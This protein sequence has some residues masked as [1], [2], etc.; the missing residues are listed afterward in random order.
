MQTFSLDPPDN[1][2]HNFTG[3]PNH[4]GTGGA[5][6]L[7]DSGDANYTYTTSLTTGS[8]TTLSTYDALTPPSGD[9]RRS[10]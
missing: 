5:D 6:A 7:F 9:Q 2:R 3:Y 1:D 8:T 4:L 10:R